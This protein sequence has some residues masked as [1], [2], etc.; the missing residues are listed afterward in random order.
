MFRWLSL[1]AFSLVFGNN[2]FALPTQDPQ[3]LLNLAQHLPASFAA[4]YDF[5]GIVALNNCSGSLV[6]LES[7]Q[8]TDPA[9]IFTNGHCRE[10]GFIAPGT[11][12][13]GE[14][15]SRRFELLGSDGSEVGTIMADRIVYGTMTGTDL[16][17]YR[18]KQTYAEILSTYGIHP[19][20]LASAHP[21]AG[22][23]I[24]VI[25]G[26]WKRGYSCAIDGFVNE[27]HEGDWTWKDSIRYTQPGCEVIGGTSGS[28]ILQAGTRTMIGIN[29]TG[30]ESGD[31]CTENNPCEV[32]PSGNITYEKGRSYGE[33][34]HQ[35]YTCINQNR[36]IDLSVPGCQLNKLMIQERL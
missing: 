29:N 8:D 28:P 9:L 25:S 18:V 26:F 32:D 4:S 14:E 11:S 24:E 15:S 21:Q 1:A 22:T 31:K 30:N 16:T 2:G 13:S 23:P 5:E 33:E 17:V 6:R 27:L 20:Q 34:T 36:E 7:S 19:L 12:V 3:A 35:L 10:G